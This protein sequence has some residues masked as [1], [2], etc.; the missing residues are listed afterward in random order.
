MLNN[1]YLGEMLQD[2]R[3]TKKLASVLAARPND[4]FREMTPMRESPGDPPI[5]GGG[6]S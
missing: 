4:A 3:H 1:R 6:R 5:F 2:D